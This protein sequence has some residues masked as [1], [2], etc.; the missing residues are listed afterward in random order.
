MAAKT[1]L[2]FFFPQLLSEFELDKISDGME[3]FITGVECGNSE[4]I[5]GKT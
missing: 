3:F 1:I 2:F 4:E 5:Q